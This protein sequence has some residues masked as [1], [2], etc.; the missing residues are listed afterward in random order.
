L[1]YY[2]F[3]WDNNVINMQKSSKYALNLETIIAGENQVTHPTVH[4]FDQPWNGYKY[5]M[6]YTPFPFADGKQENPCIAVSS[7]LVNWETPN[8]LHNPVASLYEDNCDELKDPE[9]VY[10][11]DCDELEVW[12]LGRINSSLKLNDGPLRLFR[13]RS[14]DGITWSERE[15]LY[16]FTAYKLISHSIIYEDSKYKFWGIRCDKNDNGLYYMESID[17]K[18]WSTPNR[19]S[20]DNIA[21]WHGGV[22]R[23][24][25]KYYF[26]WMGLNSIYKNKEPGLKIMYAYSTDGINFSKP[27]PILYCNSSWRSFYRPYLV[28]AD[29]KFYLYYG[30][31]GR[32]SR[33]LIA[34]S[35]GTSLESLQET[36]SDIPKEFAKPVIHL[37][38]KSIL[39]KCKHII[40]KIVFL[41][42]H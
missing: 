30:I 28:K 13:K 16:A 10:N 39:K 2:G 31:I 22:S 15:E 11:E 27:Q 38:R 37:V 23:I 42:C 12:Y 33:W 34:L 26:V 21:I 18:T 32:D 35:S 17:A 8:G 20:L 7:D 40:R 3:E 41:I 24:G 29:N 4:C 25:D 9:L 36:Y 19:T 6:A 5:Y 14:S 1:G